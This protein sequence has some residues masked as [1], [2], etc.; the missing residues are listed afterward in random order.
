MKNQ[1][2]IAAILIA[3]FF[4]CKALSKLTQFEIEY[5]EEVVI[6]STL[7]VNLPFN[8]TTPDIST[9]SESK[10]SVND[11]RKNLIEFISLKS[12]TLDLTQPED[13]NFGFLK[14]ISIYIKADGLDEIKIAWLDD[15]PSDPGTTLELNTSDEDLQEYIKMDK[16][17]LRV[18][19]ITNEIIT[20]DHHIGINSVFFVDAKI[21]GI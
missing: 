4:G 11:T 16:F 8:V 20:S 5:N 2:L 12:M 15:I 19:T 1:L 21:L 17:S 6:P 3:G 10:F 13:G 9:D 18:N 14:S 7:V